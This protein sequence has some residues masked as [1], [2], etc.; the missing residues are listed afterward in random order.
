MNNSTESFQVSWHLTV[1]KKR[2]QM[3]LVAISIENWLNLQVI[4]QNGPKDINAEMVATWR[5][6]NPNF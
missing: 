6:D 3:Y 4:A 1:K 5:Y 2:F